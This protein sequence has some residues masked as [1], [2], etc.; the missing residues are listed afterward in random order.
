MDVDGSARYPAERVARLEGLYLRPLQRQ[1][2]RLLY[3][4]QQRRD[5]GRGHDDIYQLVRHG[6]CHT[7]SDG[8]RYR[9]AYAVLFRPEEYL[10]SSIPVGCPVYDLDRSD[11]PEWL[12]GATASVPGKLAR[13]Y[14]N[15]R[16]HERLFVLR[17]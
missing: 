6:H 7:V 2:H 8:D 15:L 3:D 14:A 17:V 9:C 1:I 16:Q 13:H 10:G 5:L 12:V 11:Q 4:G